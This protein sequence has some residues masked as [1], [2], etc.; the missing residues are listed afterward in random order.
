M[1]QPAHLRVILSEHDV[2]KMTLPSEILQTVEELNLLVQITFGIAGNF[3]LH[4]KDAD[5]GN[6]FF[7][8]LSTTDISDKGTI[9]VVYI[10]P[11][12]VTLTVTD[13]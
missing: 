10:E 3:C 5:F 7:S 11:P 9:K 4:F 6:E 12:T 1:A 2:Q 8:L 13:V